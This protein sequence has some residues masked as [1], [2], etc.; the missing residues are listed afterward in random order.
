MRESMKRPW[1]IVLAG[2]LWIG[3]GLGPS[4]HAGSDVFCKIGQQADHI[5]AL[6]SQFKPNIP[7]DRVIKRGPPEYAY[8]NHIAFS[9]RDLR[10]RVLKERKRS[11]AFTNEAQARKVLSQIPS[12]LDK[13]LARDPEW[14]HAWLNGLKDSRKGKDTGDRFTLEF[15]MNEPLGRGADF[16]QG[17]VKDLNPATLTCARVVLKRDRESGEISVFTMFPVPSGRNCSR[18]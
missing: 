17:A 11:T 13:A 15:E 8:E 12:E 2:V 5:S 6:V 14:A 10:K 1:R 18:R 9:A 7:I 3:A 16:S 4:V